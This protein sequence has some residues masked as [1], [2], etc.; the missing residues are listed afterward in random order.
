MAMAKASCHVL[1]LSS[2][3]YMPVPCNDVA[4]LC[5]RHAMILLTCTYAMQWCCLRVLAPYKHVAYMYLRHAMMLLTCAYAMQW[6]CLCMQGHTALSLASMAGHTQVAKLLL[7]H[8]ADVQAKD[9]DVSIFCSTKHWTVGTSVAF[10]LAWDWVHCLM[11]LHLRLPRHRIHTSW[12]MF[13][14]HALLHSTLRYQPCSA[15]SNAYH[16]LRSMTSCTQSSVS[17]CTQL[18][19]MHEVCMILFITS[20]CI[21]LDWKSRCIT[22]NAT[23]SNPSDHGLHGWQ[24]WHC[25][26]SAVPW[27]QYS[28]CRRACKLPVMTVL[29]LLLAAVLLLL[30][31]A[32]MEGRAVLGTLL[33]G[34][35]WLSAVLA[36]PV[37]TV[38][39]L[40]C[41]PSVEMCFHCP[42]AFLSLRFH[43]RL[44]LSRL[45]QF[46]G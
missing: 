21:N 2:V 26:A 29:I 4:Y 39:S 23:G 27:G 34:H 45:R 33:D 8:G 13:C 38:Q 24:S 16:H 37:S 43:F 15:M 36:A 46:W 42:Q 12:C 3:A 20:H 25:S 31:S 6:C 30:V 28:C 18:C 10:N 14:I 22:L 19:I 1:I 17:W 44:D 35:T 41:L 5:L 7:L 11:P 40:K 9:E 32:V